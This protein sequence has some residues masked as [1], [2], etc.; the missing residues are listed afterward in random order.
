M[1]YYGFRYYDSVTGRWPSRDPI[2]ELGGLNLYGIV[3]ND[4]INMTD[5]LGN[6]AQAV[7]Y[8]TS[9][10][11]IAVSLFICPKTDSK[12]RDCCLIANGVAGAMLVAGAT[13]GALTC[14]ALLAVPVV[15]PHLYAGCIL[16]VTAAAGIH[17]AAIAISYNQCV[18][19]CGQPLACN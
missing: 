3:G 5:H 4:L 1:A 13:T 19:N 6:Y 15:G 14:H 16:A 18:S 17:G 7:A 11:A 10:A 9:A 2:G 12:C 8:V